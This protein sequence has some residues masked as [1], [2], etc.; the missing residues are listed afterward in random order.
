[1]RVHY[2]SA[3]QATELFVSRTQT[4]RLCRYLGDEA[5]AAVVGAYIIILWHQVAA[6]QTCQT[7]SIAVISALCVTWFVFVGATCVATLQ[8]LRFCTAAAFR[9]ECRSKFVSLDML[10]VRCDLPIHQIGNVMLAHGHANTQDWSGATCRER[11]PILVFDMKPGFSPDR[12]EFPL[13][14][15]T[16]AA[17]IILGCVQSSMINA[18]RDV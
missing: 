13:F 5:A 12:I 18:V 2:Q 9:L 14:A 3:P 6:P 16:E 4:V 15:I 8:R 10:T 7:Q 1:M 17:S 11:G